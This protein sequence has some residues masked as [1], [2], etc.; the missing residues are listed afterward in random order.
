MNGFP[1]PRSRTR[2]LFPSR[3]FRHRFRRR[4]AVVTAL[5]TVAASL[6]AEPARAAGPDAGRPEVKSAER[7]VRGEALGVKPRRPDPAGAPAERPRASGEVKVTSPGAVRMLDRATA[8]RVG[9]DT[10]LFTVNAAGDKATSV[11]L[12][13]SALADDFGGS[14]GSRLRLVRLPACALTT[15]DQPACRTET[16][17]RARNDVA[18]RRLTATVPA[19]ATVLAAVSGESGDKGDY[20]ATKLSPSA[21]WT[22][23]EQSGDFSWSY[24]L[25]VPPVPGELTPQ[26]EIGYSSGA[27]D[28]RTS[29]TNNQPSWI[30]EG[31]DYWPGYI[32]RAYKPCADDGAPK[33]QWGTPPGDQ[34]WAYDNAVISWNG[35]GGELIQ[36]SDGTWRMKNDDGTRVQRLKDTSKANGDDDGEYWKLTTSDGVQFFFGLNRLPGWSSG[37]PETNSAWTHPVFGDD[38]GE[39]CHASTF[40]ASWCQQAYQWNLDY[41][42]D[43]RG[44]AI[45]YYYQQERNHYGRNLKPED[46]TPYVR[47]GW[48][49]RI[50][51]GRRSDTLFTVKAPARVVFA[52][53]ERCLKTGSFDCDPGKIGSNPTKWPDV[54]FDL[55]CDAGTECKGTHGTLAPTFWSRKRLTGVTT[56]VIKADGAYRD[57]DHWAIDHL[58]G[59]A[60]IDQA[61]LVKSITHT[62]RATGS[63]VTLPSVTFNHVQL[64]NRV[65]K[66]GDDIPPFVK[67][68]LGAIYDE[69]GGQ[70]DV[71]YSE[72]DC[73]LDS[74]PTPETNTRR[75]FPVKWTPAGYDDPITDWFHKYVVTQVV[76][77]DR[78]GGSPDALTTYEY[79]GGAAWHY[80]DDDGLT[81]EKYKTWSQWRGYGRV[82]VR[83]GGWNDLRSQVE[84]RYLRGMNGDRAGPSGG[85]KKV[86]VSDGEG[87]S[88]VDEDPLQGFE[89][90][91]TEYEG[92]D[93]AVAVKTVNTPWYHET[94]KRTRSWGTVTANIVNVAKTHTWTAMD[95]G[96]WRE[97][98]TVTTYEPVAGLTTQVDDKGDLSTT[99]DDRCTRT[100][101]AQNTGAWMLRYPSRVETVAVA[102]SVT[103]DRSKHVVEDDRTFYDNGAFGAAPTRG[104][105]TRVE[106]IAAHDGTTATYVAKEVSTYDAYGRELTTKNAAG[107]VTTTTYTDTGGLNTGVKVTGPPVV[108]GDASTAHVTSEEK[109][110]AY[111]HEIVKIDANGKRTDLE[112][113]A[114]GRL[115]KVWMPDRSKAAGQTPNL[116]F[117]Y[118]VVD[119]EIVAIGTK[120]LNAEGGQTPPTYEL[121]DGRLRLRQTQEPGPDGGRL[122]TDKFYDSRGNLAREYGQYYS[123]QAPSTT[124]FGAYEG[125]VES[126]KVF[127]Y[128]G[129][130]RITLERFLVG[131]G[132]TKEKRRTVTSYGG[133][134]ITVDPP[135]G[136]TPVTTLTDAR[137]RIVELRQYRGDSPTGDYDKTTYTYTPAGKL[138][139]VTDP[140]GN[141][142]THRY[143]LRG[144]EIEV[145][146]PDK[147]TTRKTYD[148]LDHLLTTTDARGKTIFHVYDPM[149]RR[150][151]TREGSATGPLLT[152]WTYDT[153]R[154]GQVSSATRYVNGQAYTTTFNAYDNLYRAIRTTVTIPSVEGALAGSYVFDTR[155]KLDGTVQSATYPDAGG[156]PAETVVYSYDDLR[157][158]TTMSGLSTYVTDSIHSLTGKP[159]QYELST[160]GKKTWF[161]YS[162]EYGT[163]RLRSSRVDREDVPGVD[164]DATY[165][166]DAAG[167]VLSISD[168]SR[169]GIDTQCF[170]YDYLRRLTEAWTQGTQSC[171]SAPSASVVGGV[172]P[173]WQSF[174]YD[175]T[176]NRTREVEHGVG[177]VADTIRAYNYPAPGSPH[178]HALSGVTQTGGAGDRTESYTYDETGNTTGRTIGAT[179][180]TLE[181]DVEGR[182]AKVT[183]GTKVTSYL[184]DADGN[185]LIR[186]DPGGTTLYLPGLELRLD[187]VTAKVEA[188]RY[189]THDTKTVAVR[190]TAGVR[191][192]AADQNGTA[193]L[194]IDA[195]NQSLTQ[196]RFKPFGQLRGSPPGSWPGERGF[197]GG[198]VDDS[199]GLVHLGAREY[200]PAIGRFI[201]VDP[202]IDPHDPQQMN[203]YAYAGNNPVTFTD[204]DGK[205]W[206]SWLGILLALMLALLAVLNHGGGGSH[207]G[208]SGGRRGGGSGGGGGGGGAPQRPSFGSTVKSNTL[209][210]VD[211]RK[212]T[213]LGWLAYGLGA[214]SDMLKTWGENFKETR[215]VMAGIYKLKSVSYPEGNWLTRWLWRG[216]AKW[217]DAKANRVEAR[218]IKWGGRIGKAGKF[219][220]RFGVVATF[221]DGALTQWNSDS[222]RD[223]NTGEKVARAGIRGAAV[224]GGAYVG[225]SLGAA[226]CSPGVVLAAVCG[227]AGA[228]VGG[229]VGGVVGDTAIAAYD[230]LRKPVANTVKSIGSGIKKGWNSL[231]D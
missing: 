82:R 169:S 50:E 187:K 220:G 129:R 167:N 211:P 225:A 101:Y 128:D 116:E 76:Q 63:P 195:A 194:A 92:V 109:D 139:T 54:P 45:T 83:T 166:Y 119:G 77:T 87:G 173:Y 74:L 148:D 122:I 44:N 10:A 37:K 39:P 41:V 13:Y 124:L 140:A 126:Q 154:K 209:S 66:Q 25:R 217:Y 142:W 165:T 221:A 79:L 40:A 71:N 151:Q 137:G 2:R 31:F 136:D 97:T 93:G 67:Y 58:W 88:V 219:I 43:P 56:Q 131:N 99:A 231:F 178:P 26:V 14:Y 17:V 60:D 216:L 108:P 135:E 172:A 96:G 230:R 213:A 184:Y 106:T 141:V 5:A 155:Y 200:D 180:Q 20:K 33:D 138:S 160:G 24:P 46:E 8:E 65:D 157:R 62:G 51:Y 105:V 132:E 69:S 156:L 30:G 9:A 107:H 181:W 164:R 110:P 117:S 73:T 12:D 190:T 177:G 143:D 70:I 114:L 120:R 90:K 171:A 36:A 215:R 199:T 15:P 202:I 229:I 185:R 4:V 61:L 57:V 158:P 55:N 150:T 223:I 226:A 163:Q 22:V 98:E 42:V 89:L 94:A 6:V 104:D 191:F 103:P 1:H 227:A 196:R 28:G 127:D 147:G 152:A 11:T 207:G 212:F 182:L 64:P 38:A 84:I 32:K 27:V 179:A 81:R 48:L 197:V 7:V 19:D 121:Y 112:Y 170:S 192:L 228:Y 72:P 95:G 210:S 35:R 208:G 188:T 162:Y 75:C 133:G 146:D 203:G 206:T 49:D 168:V 193:E 47:G 18:N 186:R 118:R 176:G 100:T 159:E 198:T 205:F 59:D 80:D 153:V 130:N 53:S 111:G 78:T 16:P 113:D 201:S 85:T 3:R 115:L 204:P 86:T 183:E 29:N 175:V 23:A 34:C 134:R 144:R 91:R 214:P 123:T 174:A 145:R 189:Y 149:G 222:K 102:C 161:T 224:A 218:G 68:R 125:D 21:T 52:V